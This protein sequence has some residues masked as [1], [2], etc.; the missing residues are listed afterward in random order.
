MA[1]DS[2]VTNGIIAP[3]ADL[4]NVTRLAAYAIVQRDGRYLL[5][6]IAPGFPGAGRWTLPGGGLDFGED[7]AAGVLRELEEETG[8]LGRISG[9]VRVLSETGL[10][11]RDGPVNFHHVRFV[12]P[13][14]IFGGEERVEVDG[15]SDAFGWFSRD[16]I[17][18]LDRVGLLDEALA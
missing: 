11:R 18:G 10:W 2:V 15:S 14:E 9:P 7:P 12:Y 16:Q 13:V 5:C 3:M 6:R 8:L 1:F 4:P 17:A